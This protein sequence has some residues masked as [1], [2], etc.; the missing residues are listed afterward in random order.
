MRAGVEKVDMLIWTLSQTMI[1]DKKED[2]T[3]SS[4]RDVLIGTDT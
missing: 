2:V 4:L 1:Q 3:Q